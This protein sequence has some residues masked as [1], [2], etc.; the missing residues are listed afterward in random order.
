MFGLAVHEGKSFRLGAVC[1]PEWAQSPRSMGHGTQHGLRT[2]RGPAFAVAGSRLLRG[3]Q[4]LRSTVAYYSTK[5][6][7]ARWLNTLAILSQF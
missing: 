5:M 6:P 4:T 3:L 2:Q 1:T 7:P